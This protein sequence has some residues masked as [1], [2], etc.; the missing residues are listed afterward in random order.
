MNQ[1]PEYR[2]VPDCASRR[3]AAGSR[4]AAWPAK[5]AGV[6]FP[7]MT[8]PARWILAA[9]LY[10]PAPLAAQEQ[11]VLVVRAARLL[12]V[13][14]GR[15]VTPASVTVKGDRIESVGGTAP[16]GARTL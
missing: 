6:G 14:T 9:L 7:G 16:A 11:E 10:L 2:R 8:S 15:T 4:A 3:L 12:D 13:S 1:Q 5:P